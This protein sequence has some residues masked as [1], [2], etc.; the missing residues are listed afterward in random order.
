MLKYGIRVD[1]AGKLYL[2]E[3]ELAPAKVGRG[4]GIDRR[5]VID[6][7]KEIARHPELFKIFSVLEPRS[8]MAG[9]AKALRNTVIV[10]RADP[11]QYGIVSKVTAVLTDYKVPIRQIIADD[12][13]LFPD[14]VLTL[15]V[16][17]RMPTKVIDVL[18]QLEVANS[19]SIY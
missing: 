2:A 10:I 4:L 18:R 16:D 13:D 15:I 19:I 1:S 14:P 12:P 6:T 3:I 11:H 8:Q 9:V 7:A 5:V 17:G